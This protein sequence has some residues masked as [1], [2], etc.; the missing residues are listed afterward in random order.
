VSL[1]LAL[2]N[3][4][5]DRGKSSLRKEKLKQITANIRL[6]MEKKFLSL[7]NKRPVYMEYM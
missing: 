1:N 4:K 3:E 6:I 2:N 7:R 5:P